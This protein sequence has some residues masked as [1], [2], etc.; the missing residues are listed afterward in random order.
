MDKELMLAK[1]RL[2]KDNQKLIMKMELY[3]ESHYINEVTGEEILSDIVGMAL[4]CQE[5]NESFL[6]A[7]G[8]DSEAF[9]RELIRNSPRQSVIERILNMLR[10]LFLYATILVPGLALVELFFAKWSPAELVE[11]Y[12]RVPLAFLLKYY[13]FTFVLV[14]GWF[15]VRMYTYRP[16]KYVFGIYFAVFMLFFLFTE[17]VLKFV[18][19]SRMIS[20]H[21]ILAV[22]L[23]AVLTLVCHLGKRLAAFT[24][25]YHRRK[26]EKIDT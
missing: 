21:I 5:R 11:I 22:V 9:C 23:F 8:G 6:E 20:V 15:I 18:V 10:W 14:I 19:G 2:N 7:I 12:Y 24:I 26:K 16:M 17:A 25:A 13:I 3:L 1:R 4:E